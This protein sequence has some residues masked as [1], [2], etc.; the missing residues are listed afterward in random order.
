MIFSFYNNDKD[1]N[2]PIIKSFLFFF[3]FSVHFTVN[4]LFFNDNTM[5]KIYEDEGSF[6]FVYQIPQIIYSSLISLIINILIKYL[7]LSEKNI[8]KIKEEKNKKE[9]NL[10]IKK[11]YKTLKIKFALFF[12]LTFLLLLFFAYYIICFCGVYFNTQIHLIKDSFISFGLSLIYPFFLYLLPGM[13][14]I[15]ALISEGKDKEFLYKFS[16]FLQSL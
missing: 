8:L 12:I 14:R 4:A 13:F 5:H 9:F 16:Q 3:L 1:Y 10:E 2:S 7:S 15:P 11:L 6:N